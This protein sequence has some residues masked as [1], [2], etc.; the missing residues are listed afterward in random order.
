M[1][2][3]PQCARVHPAQLRLVTICRSL[4]FFSINLVESRVVALGTLLKGTTQS[5]G[6]GHSLAVA[7]FG[8]LHEPLLGC[9]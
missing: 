4:F 8:E 2:G 3:G 1:V 6:K 9:P 7:D 5:T